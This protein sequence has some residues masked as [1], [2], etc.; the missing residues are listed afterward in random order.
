MRVGVTGALAHLSSFRRMPRCPISVDGRPHP[1][2]EMGEYR[3]PPASPKAIGRDA[4]GSRREAGKIAP[5]GVPSDSRSL[6][7]G[8]L[9]AGVKG[10][11]FV[12]GAAGWS[13]AQ[14]GECPP[15]NVVRPVGRCECRAPRFADSRLLLIG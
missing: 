14:S 1:D 5:D 6:A 15:N 8:L 2:S 12:R 10:Q 11:V 7:S 9:L 13:A 4:G 3:T